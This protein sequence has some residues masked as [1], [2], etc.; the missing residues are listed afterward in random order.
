MSAFSKLPS[1][2]LVEVHFVWSHFNTTAILSD[3][4]QSVLPLHVKI[5]LF[6][7][8]TFQAHEVPGSWWHQMDCD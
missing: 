2:P 6:M 8:K 3:N 1:L 7:F 4:I 5:D